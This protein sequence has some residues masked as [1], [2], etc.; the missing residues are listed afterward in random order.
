MWK[1]LI[2]TLLVT[3]AVFGIYT[4]FFH[5]ESHQNFVVDS[6]AWSNF[7]SFIGG[8]L[9]PILSAVALIAVAETLKNQKDSNLYTQQI[10]E[11]KM[12]ADDL[13]VTTEQF[14]QLILTPA[15]TF[16]SKTIS[17]M[18]NLCA[19]QKT[20]KSVEIE[21][22]ATSIIDTLINISF[23]VIDIEKR[24]QILFKDEF[25]ALAFKQKWIYK[26]SGI[27]NNAYKLVNQNNYNEKH[28]SALYKGLGIK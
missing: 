27:G 2:T 28:K 21:S 25:A 23:I 10:E 13:L 14:D 6:Q 18:I 17:E 12:R 15:N 19:N 5:F 26:Y 9:S 1:Y 8:V 20:E 11:I 16:K 7:G 4:Y 24:K 3:V 22:C